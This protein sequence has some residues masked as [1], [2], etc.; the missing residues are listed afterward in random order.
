M[1]GHCLSLEQP[2][3]FAT[4]LPLFIVVITFHGLSSLVA[5]VVLLQV[6]EE[7]DPASIEHFGITTVEVMSSGVIPVGLSRGGSPSI[8]THGVN[9]FLAGNKEEFITHTVQLFNMS[10]NDLGAMQSA[11]RA[12]TERYS[13]SR[14]S[15]SFDTI[16]VRGMLSEGYRAF[17]NE[18]VVELRKK[19]LVLPVTSRKVAVIVEPGVK[20][21]FEYVVRNVMMELGPE[22]ALVVVH[23]KANAAFVNH[24]L[25]DVVNVRF[26]GLEF[27]VS[28]I[29]AYNRLLKSAWFW[30][31][32]QADKALIFQSD[33]IMVGGPKIDEFFEYDYVGAPWHLTNEIFSSEYA[34][35]IGDGIGNGGFSLRSVDAM[36]DICEA[37]GAS[38][39]DTEAEDVFFVVN[40]LKRGYQFPSRQ[41]A[42]SFAQEVPCSDLRD[43]RPLG[44]HATWYYD[45]KVQQKYFT[46]REPLITTTT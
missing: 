46:S 35:L 45:K 43:V 9:G 1:I 23:A 11:A 7:E 4:P 31:M 26:Y 40:L 19:R 8:I 41:V 30:K 34:K 27:E 28:D 39:P 22:W 17:I 12:A 20:P 21:E 5:V 44:L 37:L 10:T 38:S 18:N 25:K 3:W 29:G 16:C 15:K 42:Y 33:S 13:F 6:D 2:K 14:F 36:I 32:L 24:V